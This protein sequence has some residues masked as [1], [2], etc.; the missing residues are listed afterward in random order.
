ML[1]PT[2]LPVVTIFPLLM[3]AA[4]P[5]TGEIKSGERYPPKMYLGDRPA[6]S[7]IHI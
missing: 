4:T 5:V 2:F 3:S 1:L 6:T 7:E